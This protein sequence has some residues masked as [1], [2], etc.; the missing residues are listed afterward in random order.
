MALKQ[1]PTSQIELGMYIHS[2]EGS[3]LSHPF[4]RAR[5]LVE[6]QEKLETLRESALDGVVIDTDRGIDVA[7]K[8]D[9]AP[10]P[11]GPVLHSDMKARVRRREPAAASPARPAAP[12]R[13]IRAA[14]PLAGSATVA[15]EFGNARRTVGQ[16]RKVISKIF[17]E[18]RLGKAPRVAD[19]TP[20]V[21]DIHASIERNAHAFSGLMRCKTEMEAIYQHM[22]SVSA[23]MVSLAREMRLTPQ[24]TRLAGMAGLLLDIGVS[25]LEI[26][27]AMMAGQLDDIDE[28]LWQRHCYIGRE[29]LAAAD[30]VPEEVLH[31]VMRHHEHM[32]GSG[33]PQSL[34][35]RDIDLFSRMAA[36]CDRFDL[37]VAGAV[38]GQAVDPAE[39]M[40]M[41]METEDAFDSEILTRFR[42]ALGVYPVGSFVK[43]RS[44]RIAM[45]V[46]QDPSEPALP[47]VRAFYSLAAD[48]HVATKTIAL[49][50]CYG[51]D[52]ITGVADISGLDLPPVEELRERLF[53]ASK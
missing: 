4:W 15:R 35:E 45:V 38:T 52:A 17:I 8:A 6:D 22:L 28:E 12:A 14:A 20:V 29:L 1:I 5:F 19:V 16:A 30:D 27:N 48:K 11:R 26:G 34:A 53:S 23:L 44:E 46:D 7:V 25:R 18:A 24:E 3:W 9:E 36:I 43:L 33:F 40:R 31:A 10:P 21:E 49:A 50:E 32:D 2:F 39:A 41:M 37:I 51:E 13:P 42:E 47:T